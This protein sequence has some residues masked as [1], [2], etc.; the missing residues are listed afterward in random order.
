MEL[1][2]TIEHEAHQLLLLDVVNDP[3]NF[4]C[5]IHLKLLV[6]I[7]GYRHEIFIEGWTIG[8]IVKRG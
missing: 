2:I 5:V 4:D 6:A 8:Q 1:E 3:H 7:A